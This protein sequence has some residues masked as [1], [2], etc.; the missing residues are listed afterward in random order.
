MDERPITTKGFDMEAGEIFRLF[1]FYAL[2]RFLP[3]GNFA[4]LT[5]FR[6]LAV[7]TALHHLGRFLFARLIPYEAQLTRLYARLRKKRHGAVS[8]RAT[9]EADISCV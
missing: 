7:L 9:S 6:Q 5:R 2:N 1:R 4:G 3:L 8:P